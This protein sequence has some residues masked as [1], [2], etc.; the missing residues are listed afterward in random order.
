LTHSTQ[1]WTQVRGEPRSDIAFAREF[2][3]QVQ[4]DE[5]GQA[6][7]NEEPFKTGPGDSLPSCDDGALA[8][9]HRSVN[10]EVSNP[11]SKTDA[12]AT[13]RFPTAPEVEGVVPPDFNGPFPVLAESPSRA[14]HH[15]D[16]EDQHDILP[17]AAQ[18]LKQPEPKIVTE[19]VQRRATIADEPG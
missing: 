9:G 4:A 16:R 8:V 15:T 7:V 12:E 3:D 2:A 13:G 5:P 19:V 6:A 1:L 17:V 14:V 10:Q 11:E 18:E